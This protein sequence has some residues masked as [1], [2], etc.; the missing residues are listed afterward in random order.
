M[1]SSFV[2]PGT[3]PSLKMCRYRFSEASCRHA[4]VSKDYFA[5]ETC[6]YVKP[7]SYRQQQEANPHSATCV[8]K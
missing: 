6:D 1:R 5:A 2:P 3:S 8:R 7:W 4:T